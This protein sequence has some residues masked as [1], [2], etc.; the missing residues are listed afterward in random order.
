MMDGSKIFSL[1][2]EVEG[3]LLT[4]LC[5][6]DTTKPN[7]H[8]HVW[9]SFISGTLHIWKEKVKKYLTCALMYQYA[10]VCL[11]LCVCQTKHLTLKE[12][13]CLLTVI[14]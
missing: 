11:P 14:C 5:Q 1:I 4:A 8:A 13:G 9:H 6:T 3:A 12:T 7:P 10:A 2:L